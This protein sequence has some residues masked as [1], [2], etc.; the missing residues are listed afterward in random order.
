MGYGI[1]IDGKDSAGGDFYVIDSDTASTE[2]LGVSNGGLYTNASD[3]RSSITSASIASPTSVTGWDNTQ[4]TAK[5]FLFARPADSGA[6]L[7]F[8]GSTQ[9]MVPCEYVIVSPISNTTYL[10]SNVNGTYGIQVKNSSGNLIFD[11]RKVNRGFEIKKSLETNAMN[12]G[13]YF[14]TTGYRNGNLVYDGSSLTL[15]QWRNTYVSIIGS[16]YYQ[17]LDSNGN[18]YIQVKIGSFYFVND[19]A[20]IGETSYPKQQIYYQGYNKVIGIA[21]TSITNLAAILVGEYLE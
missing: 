13:E 8:N 7:L 1:K 11:S 18:L 12:G 19:A 9:A 10:G 21:Q 2:F 15:A 3:G 17:E 6:E 20:T 16:H 5:Q 14:D 4:S